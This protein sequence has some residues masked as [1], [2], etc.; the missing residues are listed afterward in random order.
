MLLSVSSC[1]RFEIVRFPHGWASVQGQSTPPGW[2]KPISC[3]PALR[4]AD[5]AGPSA[6][7]ILSATS[8]YLWCIM[9]TESAQLARQ[10]DTR[11]RTA[12][13]P[14]LT[15]QEERSQHPWLPDHTAQGV[16]PEWCSSNAIIHGHAP[17]RISAPSPASRPARGTW[18][19]HSRSATRRGLYVRKHGNAIRVSWDLAK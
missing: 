1:S 16:H 17:P 14:T 10:A 15:M 12:L 4:A 6:T 9:A 8:R 5:M 18:P 13:S 3:L 7:T 11:M 2:V 19:G